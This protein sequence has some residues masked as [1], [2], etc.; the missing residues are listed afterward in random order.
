M[1]S[2]QPNNGSIGRWAVPF[3]A[4]PEFPLPGRARNALVD[5][6]LVDG[7]PLANIRLIEDPT[8]NLVVIMKDGKRWK[9]VLP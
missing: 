7:D 3:V 9:N 1:L 2:D 4:R 8:R 5:L 6:L